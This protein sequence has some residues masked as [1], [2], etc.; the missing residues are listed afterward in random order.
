MS[1]DNSGILSR[2]VDTT[3]PVSW[4]RSRRAA[5]RNIT[6]SNM[7]IGNIDKASLFRKWT[8]EGPNSCYKEINRSLL[9]DDL[10]TLQKH[11]NYINELRRAIKENLSWETMKVYRGLQL[12]SSEIHQLKTGMA[13][14]WPTFSSTS[15]IRS[16][17]QGFGNYLFE[18]DTSPNDG[19]YRADIRSYS[20][21]SEEEVLFYPYSG[22]QVKNIFKDARVIQLQCID[23]NR[24]EKLQNSSESSVQSSTYG[25]HQNSGLTQNFGYPQSSGLVQSS[26]YL[27]N[28]GRGQSF[29]G[30]FLSSDNTPIHLTTPHTNHSNC[31][32]YHPVYGVHHHYNGQCYGHHGQSSDGQ[33][34]GF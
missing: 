26:N 19:I 20:P 11:A 25:Y 22:F 29:G 14:L 15:R 31:P 1:R 16:I 8:I 34:T 27:Q 28:S 3:S 17:A 10:Y 4:P 7:F 33:N 5:Y 21:Y 18:I 9:N 32:H 30:F 6:N 2:Y 23:T 24:V 12:E 13:F